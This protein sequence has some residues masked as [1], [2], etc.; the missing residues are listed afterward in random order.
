MLDLLI[1]IAATAVGLGGM[2]ALAPA[3]EVFTYPY[4]PITPSPWLGWA[5]VTAS[6]WAFYLS[7]LLAAW[8]LGIVTLRLRPPRPRRLA[9]QPG[10]V[11]CCAAATGSVAGTVMTVIG[12]RGR[13]GMMSF[14]ELVAYPVGVAV[15]A[16][17]T[18]L[19]WSGQWRA[20]PTWIDR[21]GR[22][23]GALWL[24]MLPLLWGRYLFSH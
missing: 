5:S 15:L 1:L 14:F 24:A 7:P 2:R 22:I 23:V 17:W 19:A 11:G 21:A 16:V 8:T 12:I 3:N 13:Y 4:A 20:E 18:H 6:N 9:F 10:W